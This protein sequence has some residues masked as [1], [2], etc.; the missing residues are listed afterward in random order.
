M[1]R[2][3]YY[4]IFPFIFVRCHTSYRF[5]SGGCRVKYKDCE[6]GDEREASTI[7]SLTWDR[8]F[9]PSWMSKTSLQAKKTSTMI[10][11]P[12]LVQKHTHTHTHT[13]THKHTHTHTHTLVASTNVQMW[14]YCS[15]VIFRKTTLGHWIA[16]LQPPHCNPVL[17]KKT[18]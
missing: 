13:H 7:M 2:L 9:V 14:C 4:F 8:C 1:G 10:H 16:I 5:L 17:T 15:G 12:T 11:T 3:I 6:N 18:H